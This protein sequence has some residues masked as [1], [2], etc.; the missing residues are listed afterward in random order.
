MGPTTFTN[1]KTA[2]NCDQN[3]LN[4]NP[5]LA[6]PAGGDFHLTFTSPAIDTGTALSTVTTDFEGTPRPQGPAYDIGADELGSAVSSPTPTPTPTLT[7]TATPIPSTSASFLTTDTATQ[8]TWKQTYG[9]EGYSVIGDTQ[10]LP[11]YAQITPANNSSFTW[12]PSTT[13][14][15]ALQKGGTATDRIASAWYNSNAFTL[16][17]SDPNTH[18]I[19]LYFLDWDSTTRTQTVEVLDAATNVTLDTRTLSSFNPGNYLVWNIKGNVIFRI[20]RT[21]GSNGVLSGMFVGGSTPSPTPTPGPIACSQYTPSSA[22]PTGYASPYDVASSPSTNLMNVTCD[23]SSA[24]IDLGKGDPLQY[25]YNQGYLFKTGGSAWTLV[26]YTSTESL[27]AGA[28]YPKTATTNLSPTSTELAN[29]SYNL[30]YTCT[31][32]GSQ[33]KCGCRDSACTQSYWQIQSFKR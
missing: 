26:P 16:T 2:C 24:R 8:G 23:V 3:S 14:L 9:S 10:S 4:V 31:W 5:L 30:A 7:P 13:E 17:L 28:W 1:W 32:T 25:I 12:A 29:P 27:I 20:T 6:N 33:W 19:A 11:S 22:I 15:R 21:G 18:K